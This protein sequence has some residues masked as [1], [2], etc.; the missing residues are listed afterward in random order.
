MKAMNQI[1]HI[2]AQTN[3]ILGDLTT[4]QINKT[5]RSFAL[6]Y[7]GGKYMCQGFFAQPLVGKLNSLEGLEREADVYFRS[8]RMVGTN[9][10]HI[11]LVG[12]E[13]QIH[14]MIS[15]IKFY[16]LVRGISTTLNEDLR[17][18]PYLE[19]GGQKEH[20]DILMSLDMGNCC[21]ANQVMLDGKETR[22]HNVVIVG[23]RMIGLTP[24]N[25]CVIGQ[26]IPD[27]IENTGMRMEVE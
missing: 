17:V 23:D 26:L 15:D 16:Q 20:W 7:K 22:I 5:T 13:D 24:K 2:K 1:N 11:R 25:R 18:R 21:I 4:T 27:I 10:F 9:L 14:E 8:I 12:D 19:V 6:Y 3:E